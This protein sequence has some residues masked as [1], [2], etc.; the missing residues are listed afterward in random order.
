M[1]K[2]IYADPPWNMQG[3]TRTHK[4]EGYSGIKGVQDV[5]PLMKTEEIKTIYADCPWA[6]GGGTKHGWSKKR[7]EA[8]YS[9]MPLDD[10][11]S[12]QFD[13]PIAEQAHLWLWVTNGFIPQGLEVMEAWGFKYITSVVWVKNRIGLGQ[14]IRTKHETLLF[15]RKGKPLPYKKI[16]GKRVTVPSAFEAPLTKHS[17]KPLEVYQM[18]EK[19]S[20][21]PYLELF[22]RNIEVER[23]DWTYWGNEA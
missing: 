17:K 6:L 23:P 13:Y 9:V 11:K 5:Y 21:P 16:D 10:I 4:E 14:Y 2:T 1:I 22:A 12:L 3:G 8:K 19:V 20:Y 7:P 15:G 18:I